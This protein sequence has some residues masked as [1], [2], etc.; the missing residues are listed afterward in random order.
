MITNTRLSLFEFHYDNPEKR[1][2]ALFKEKA[3][4]EE[5]CENFQVCLEIL[6]EKEKD[7][8]RRIIANPHVRRIFNKLGY[9]GWDKNPVEKF[10]LVPLKEA[11]YKMR[12]RLLKFHFKG[13][14]KL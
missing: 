3:L 11:F 8:S 6:H 12:S 9:A 13:I 2:I 4:T 14:G 5:F 7:P 1:Q 10:Y